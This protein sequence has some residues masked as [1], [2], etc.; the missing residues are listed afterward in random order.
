MST[1][2]WRYTNDQGVEQVVSTDE[3]CAA[4][5]S[6]K[7]APSTSVWRDGMKEWA[8]AFSMPEL[9]EAITAGTRVSRGSIPPLAADPVRLPT[10]PPVP[11]PVGTPRGPLQTLTGLEPVELAESLF[12][13]TPDGAPGDAAKHSSDAPADGWNDVTDL[14]PKA[15]ALPHDAPK[16]VPPRSARRVP[17]LPPPPMPAIPTPPPNNPYP[18]VAAARRP[19]LTGT[20]HRISK[21]PPPPPRPKSIPPHGAAARGEISDTALAPSAQPPGGQAPSTR[22]RSIP[23]APPRRLHKTLELGS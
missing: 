3:L 21:P 17:S 7:L 22:P 19:T 9:T 16:I 1:V 12:Q 15:P 8:P 5:A 14:I 2:E 13:T 11:I 4:L 6:G 23:P 20:G 10:P 18:K